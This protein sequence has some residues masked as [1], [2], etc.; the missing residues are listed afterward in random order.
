MTIFDF[1]LQW[2]IRQLT[3]CFILF[4]LLRLSFFFHLIFVDFHLI[5]LK[6]KRIFMYFQYCRAVFWIFFSS[7]LSDQVIALMT[8]SFNQMRYLI[9][10]HED[11]EWNQPSLKKKRINWKRMRE[12]EGMI[13]MRVMEKKWWNFSFNRIICLRDFLLYVSLNSIEPLN[14]VFSN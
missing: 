14:S 6:M 4:F 5:R 11:F 7:H 10:C 2:Y 13:W 3:P 9:R 8:I 1:C 12:R